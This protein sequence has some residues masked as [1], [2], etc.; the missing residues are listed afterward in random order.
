MM[1]RERERAFSFGL[2][3]DEDVKRKKEKR[4]ADVVAG[5]EKEP[6]T[7]PRES[8]CKSSGRACKNSYL[9]KKTN[10]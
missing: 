10:A 5:L 7:N 3:G 6:G 1:E 8:T 2:D 4:T 9:S